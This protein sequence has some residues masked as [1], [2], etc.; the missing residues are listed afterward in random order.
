MNENKKPLWMPDVD[1]IAK[2]NLNNFIKFVVNKFNL[3]LSNYEDLYNWSVE[4]TE[5]FWI[6]ILE[7]SNIIYSG[8]LTP[9][10]DYKHDISEV[11]PGALWFKN[12]RI[13]FAENLLKQNDDNL[14]IIAYNEIGETNKI[15]YS[16]LRELV[17]SIQGY[18]KGKG[19]QRGDRIAGLMTNIPETVEAMLASTSL[20]AVWTSTSPDFG[21]TGILDR[22]T[23]VQP[24]I[25]FTVDGYMFNGKKYSILQ[26]LKSIKNELQC[27][28]LV[29]ISVIHTHEE[30]TSFLGDDITFFS[31]IVQQ[32]S[33]NDLTFIRSEFNHPLYIMFSSG[34]TG[35]P[36]CIVH[37]TGGTLLQHYKELALHTDL[38]PNDRIFYF[39]TCG[40]MMWNWL[41]SSLML[42]S[43]IVLF[44][45]SP[46]YPNL[47]TLWEMTDKLEVNIFGTSPKF[48]SSCQTSGFI[49][50]DKFNLISLRVILST[51]AP[52]LKSNFEWVYS[53]VKKEVRLSSISG[54]TDIISC[55]ALGNP[56]MPVYSEELQCIGLGMKVQSFNEHGLPVIG[57]KGELVCTRIFPSMP[58]YFL[59]DENYELYK[60]S[61]FD[62]F[63]NV[64]HHGDYVEI[65]ENGG[66]IVYGRSDATLNPGGV[67]IGTAEIYNALTKLDY[68]LDSVAVGLNES[69]D[70]SVVLF[71]VLNNMISLTHEIEQQI[72]NVIRTELTPRHVP[73]YI[74][75]IED[76][77]V[78]LN[79]KKV[80]IVISRI[81][82]GEKPE[83]IEAI[84]NPQS[85]HQFYDL[86]F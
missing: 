11:V 13:N 55:F 18:L 62:R 32:Y 46:S 57:K 38:K 68:I 20:G 52:L 72:K 6:S 71:V 47:G 36:K 79:G 51:G 12:I 65:T 7:F 60:K 82:N 59:N 78:T 15:H 22:F 19:I 25:L 61:Y 2:S 5:E 34:T 42:G 21:L 17:S 30:I 67:R 10:L 74:R 4:Q 49:P 86:K 54:G 70:V 1:T 9:V 26:T 43:T 29:V 39:T 41:V 63:P 75:Q 31:D 81:I 80:E 44:D 3:N 64:W 76:I 27:A 83:N 14:A 28:E 16:K 85:L 69:G 37:G 48:L 45:G 84:A 8:E 40:W 73:K 56:L 23:Q 66:L 58:I 24:K 53:H 77:P 33:D 50:S 35:K